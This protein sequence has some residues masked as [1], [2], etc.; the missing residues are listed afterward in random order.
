MVHK[1]RK[2]LTSLPETYEVS[3][4]TVISFRTQR[5]L[6]DIEIAACRLFSIPLENQLTVYV[7]IPNLSD[8][9]SEIDPAIWVMMKERVTSIRIV[10]EFSARRA[11][12]DAG[13]NREIVVKLRDPTG[14]DSLFVVR[15][16]ISFSA[17]AKAYADKH[18]LNLY[19]IRLMY[20][21]ER[22]GS[23]SLEELNVQN[24]DVI[25]VY[26][27]QVGGKPVIYLFSPTRISARVCLHL[28]P[29]WSFSA[30]YPTSNIEEGN[31]GQ[32]IAWDVIVHPEG[33]MTDKL[34][35]SNVSYLYW[36]AR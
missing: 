22:W 2:V 35:G 15:P 9:E 33:T 24:G 10:D 32:K 29:E 13:M 5:R 1:E 18:A 17:L 34:T 14:R 26:F 25:D 20:D 36:E 3:L 12:D 16:S 7:L 4:P 27:E 30:I 21:A 23:N 6:Q 11:K 8:S 28:V 31:D 19:R